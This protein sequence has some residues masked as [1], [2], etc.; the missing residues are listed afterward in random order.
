MI[1]QKELAKKIGIKKSYMSQVIN[2]DKTVSG[3]FSLEL[4]QRTGIR[5]KTWLRGGRE[6]RGALEAKFGPIN[7]GRGRVKK[8]DNK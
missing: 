7:M 3:Q 5:S 4:E 1:L 8:G 2:G 6:L